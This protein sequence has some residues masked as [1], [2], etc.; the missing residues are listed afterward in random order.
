MIHLRAS[1]RS[2]Q[3]SE[4]PSLVAAC[5]V[6]D[7]GF[8][9]PNGQAEGKMIRYQFRGRDVKIATR[10]YARRD[11]ALEAFRNRIGF[12]HDIGQVSGDLPDQGLRNAD[13]LDSCG[14]VYVCN[15]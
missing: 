12:I 15:Q 3:L 6:T 14:T 4:K 13:K 1:G 7:G 9:L 8:L 10:W 5:P 11:M 2:Q